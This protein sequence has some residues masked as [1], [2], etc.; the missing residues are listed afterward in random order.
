MKKLSLILI[1]GIIQF[2][3]YPQDNKIPVFEI[4]GQVMTDIGYNFNQVN[5]LYFDVMRPTQL[6]AYKNEFGTDGNVYFGVRQSSLGFKSYTNTRFGELRTRFD[7][8]LFGV[9]ANAGQTTFHMLYAWVELGKLGVGHHWSLFCDFDGFP[10]I[11][12]YWGPSGM[13][14]CKNVQVRYSPI[15]GK[16]RITFALERPG[17]SADEGIYRDRIELDDVE[18]KFNLP[19]FTAEFRMTRDWG[20]A[21]LSGALRK[22]EWVDQGIYDSYDLSGKALGWGFNLSSKLLLGSNDAFKGQV[23]YGEGIQNLMNDAT[24][25][26]GIQNNFGNPTAPVKGVALPIFSFSTYLD[27][28]WNEKFTSSVGFSLVNITNSD[29]QP[30]DAYRQ[31]KYASINLL[32]YPVPNLMAGTELIWISRDNFRDDWHTTATK[33]QFSCRYN[34]LHR[35][36]KK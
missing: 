19:D 13:S 15:V 5:P 24:T 12:E 20:Y 36:D 17:A 7:F 18:P 27:H 26:I 11:V 34:F 32:Y 9:G 2:T 23:I 10:N 8:D 35:F 14:L 29:A 28:K 33:I 16:N 30:D 31:G 3:A 4:Y 22:I 25:D 21:E 1:I 6:P